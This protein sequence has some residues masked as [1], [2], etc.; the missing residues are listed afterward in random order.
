MSAAAVEAI[1]AQAQYQQSII[2]AISR[3][4][5]AKP[6]RDY[7]PIFITQA[8]IDGGR[9]FLAEH[10]DEL[11]RG[12][13]RIRRAGRGHRRDHRR[14]NQLRRHH[15]QLPRCSMRCTR[16]PSYYPAKRAT[17]SSSA[18]SWRSCSRWRKET[19]S[20]STTLKG[21]YAGAMGWGQFMPSS[22]REYAVD[23]DGDGERDLFD[24]AATSSPRSPTTSS[25]TAGSAAGRWSLRANARRRTR[26]RSTPESLEPTYH[27]RRPRRARLPPARTRSRR[28]SRRHAGDA[29]RQRTA[30]STGSAS[31]TST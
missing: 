8:R 11:A 15:R 3:P 21:S 7:R 26:S 17:P 9:A 28:R 22:Y 18:A 2:D 5:E 14:R 23:G 19:G 27:A 1:L 10:R 29:R 20:T 25:R 6:W 4:A 30:R 12:P 16:W 13:K 31:T 24:E